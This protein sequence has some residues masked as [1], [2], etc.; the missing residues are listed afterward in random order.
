MYV[1][2]SKVSKKEEKIVGF[3][4]DKQKKKCESKIWVVFEKMCNKVLLNADTSMVNK[5]N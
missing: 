1:L 2:K 3:M 5:Y 4:M